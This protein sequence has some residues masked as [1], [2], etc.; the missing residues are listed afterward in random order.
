MIIAFLV[1]GVGIIIV[2]GCGL[3]YLTTV[4]F[5]RGPMPVA[6]SEPVLQSPSQDESVSSTEVVEVYIICGLCLNPEGSGASGILLVLWEAPKEIGIQRPT[7]SHGDLC[8]LL[9]EAEGFD[10]SPVSLIRC[11]SGEGW[12]DNDVLSFTPP[13]EFAS[14]IPP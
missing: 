6:P 5:P 1:T 13:G 9:E 4:V 7:V 8:V 12:L 10:G 14:P 11:P 2:F 3:L